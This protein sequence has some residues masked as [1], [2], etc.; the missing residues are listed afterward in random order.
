MP[1]NATGA[2]WNDIASRKRAERDA[3]IP[4]DWKLDRKYLPRENG[5]PENVLSVP[6]ECGILTAR[7]IEIT[8]NY[9]SVC[10]VGEITSRRLSAQE[11]TLAFCKRAAITQQLTN[12]LTEP[13]FN[14]ALHRAEF[15][16]QYYAEHGKPLGTLHGLPVSVKDTFNITGVDSSIGIAALCFKPAKFNS[17]LVDLL[18]SLGCVII[19]KTNVPQT[20][21]SLATTTSS[22]VQ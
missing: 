8:S 1:S 12:C 5:E 21:G 3:T 6:D 2:S 13:L 10:L 4:A 20:L 7:E 15:L 17:P 19:A 14:S 18:L 16:D 9:N 22:D 11:V